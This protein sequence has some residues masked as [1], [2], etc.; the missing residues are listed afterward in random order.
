[1]QEKALRE[2]VEYAKIHGVNNPADLM[3]KH[4][5]QDKIHAHMNNMNMHFIGGR[6]QI[7]PG[8]APW[9]NLEFKDGCE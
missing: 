3:T 7:A 2:I 6:P 1:M 9:R 4:V 5:P 8:T